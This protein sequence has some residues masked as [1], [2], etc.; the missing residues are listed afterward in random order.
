MTDPVRLIAYF[1]ANP[2]RPTADDLVSI[3]SPALFREAFEAIGRSRVKMGAL[4]SYVFA[5]GLS[6]LPE[7]AERIAS[8]IQQFEDGEAVV[9]VSAVVAQF[10]ALRKTSEFASIPNIPPPV[11]QA[12]QDLVNVQDKA[13]YRG[14]GTDRVFSAA[15]V[16]AALKQRVYFVGP[17]FSAAEVFL[18]GTNLGKWCVSRGVLS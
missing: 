8:V 18:G 14:S 11:Q 13:E 9:D 17:A 15:V 10:S 1:G 6:V 12:I 3:P 16:P 7:E 5:R 4:I 2:P